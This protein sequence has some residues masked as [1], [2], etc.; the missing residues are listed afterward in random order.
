MMAGTTAASPGIRSGHKLG[1]SLEAKSGKLLPHFTALT[2]GAPNPGVG[3]K[4]N[5]FK[6]V[7]A[8]LTMELKDGHRQSPY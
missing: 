6:I 8:A 4:N 7:L 5:L 2:A 3:I 1:P